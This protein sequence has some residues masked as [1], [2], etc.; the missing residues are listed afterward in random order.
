MCL[1][2][3]EAQHASL[4]TLILFY[5]IVIA[6]RIRPVCL[7]ISQI[8]HSNE[9][10]SP[11]LRLNPSEGYIWG[12]PCCAPLPHCFLLPFYC[13]WNTC[14]TYAPPSLLLFSKSAQLCK[15]GPCS[16]TGPQLKPRDKNS[17]AVSAGG[18]QIKS[19]PVGPF[20]ILM[21]QPCSFPLSDGEEFCVGVG[22]G[23]QLWLWL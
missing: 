3:C 9:R 20:S 19:F 21:L 14:H 1:P 6:N 11:C 7:S 10:N 15:C 23:L 5:H 2:M 16:A 12:V 13:R 17:I 22:E 8:T 4:K 18:E